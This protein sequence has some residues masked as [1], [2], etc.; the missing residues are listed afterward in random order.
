[1]GDNMRTAINK[2][3]S[4]GHVRTYTGKL[5]S[6]VKPRALDVEIVDI[7]HALGNQCRWSGHTRE[8]YSVAEHSMR[9]A[10]LVHKRLQHRPRAESVV[11]ELQAL[12]HDATEAYLGD[13]PSPIKMMLVEYKPIEER[14][15]AAICARYTLPVELPDVVHEA[16]GT[17]LLV[18]ARDLFDVQPPVSSFEEQFPL[19]AHVG[20]IHFPHDSVDATVAFLV[21]FGELQEE[22]QRYGV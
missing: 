18:E 12:L 11:P 13:V 9:V 17:M 2:N 10:D 6:L 3:N 14:V 22:R 1:M 4:N 20:K 21:R 7:A 5:F 19:V 16:D 15:H 8:H